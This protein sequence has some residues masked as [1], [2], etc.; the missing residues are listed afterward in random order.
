[1]TDMHCQELVDTITAYLENT[2]AEPDRERFD[3]HLAECPFCTEYLAQMRAT[4]TRLGTIDESTLSPATRDGLLAVFRA[5]RGN[6]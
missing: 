6:R 4:I 3:A 1:M 2:L 5:E